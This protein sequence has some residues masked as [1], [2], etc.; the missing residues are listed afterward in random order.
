MLQW[1]TTKQV[2]FLKTTALVLVFFAV[3]FNLS[4]F[5]A[6][7]PVLA[8][9]VSSPD[10]TLNQ[11]LQVIEQ[12]L[13][14]A[15][16]DIR[17]IIARIIRIAL[18]LV[19]LV[20]VIMFIYAGFL[21]MTAGGN[22]EQLGRAKKILIN[23]TV[24]L[25]II[26]SAYAIVWFVMRL[27]GV[28]GQPGEVPP[29]AF[30]QNTQNFRGSGALGKIV[31]DHYPARDEVNIPRNTKLVITFSKPVLVSS[32]TN[33]TNRNG[34]FGD[35]VIPNGRALNWET[36]CDS[37]KLGDN[38]I[39]IS[40]VGSQ[41]GQL[42]LTPVRGAAVLA[43]YVVESG[44]R[45]SY[46]VVLRPYDVLGSDQE[47][48][49]YVVRLGDGIKLDLPNNPGAFDVAILGNNYYEWKFICSKVLDTVPPHV[50]N[51]Y[52]NDGDSVAKN[53]AIQINFDKPIDP[54]GVQGSF[55]VGAG[56][57]FLGGEVEA[58][59]YVYLT[60]PN[61]NAP[62][63][64]FN[65]VNNYRTLEFVSTLECGVNACGG[66]IF[67][68]PVCDK[69]G[70]NCA[71]DDYKI[72][73][74]AGLALDPQNNKF[75]A[76]PFSGIVDLSGNALDSG[77]VG[78]VEVAPRNNPIFVNQEQPDNYYWGFNV[79][80]E[81]DVTSPFINKVIPGLDAQNVAPNQVWSVEFNKKML[82]SSLYSISITEYP[83]PAARCVGR[84]NCEAVPMWKMPSVS[85]RNNTTVT[86]SHGP[87]LDGLRQYYLP[88]ISSDVT[89]VNYNCMYPGK[90][91]GTP[92]QVNAKLSES[93]VCDDTPANRAN[94]CVVAAA[95]PNGDAS[96]A[97]CCNGV[98][99]A[100]A[101]SVEECTNYWANNVQSP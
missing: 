33:N 47:E 19:G 24:G 53:T 65:L 52:P 73:L 70:A 29:V 20:M 46:T 34:V 66:K 43:S 81:L 11:G 86:I 40:S 101:A 77:V 8:Q 42:T 45:R 51:V 74:K 72:L 94:C 79:T 75:E 9:E 64:F 83:T 31:R 69:V 100:A 54:T 67:C 15:A 91:P 96:R 99:N 23:A 90:G 21:W 97:F 57:Y 13:G 37:L 92:A 95:A 39:N 84:Q 50:T 1:I 62:A 82:I 55:N 88:N 98:P 4:A 78:K 80:K 60:S 38:F 28:E 5:L 27:L 68:L 35:C 36:D 22:E 30:E 16:T 7:S 89:D 85:G 6:V 10:S 63:G 48:I 87:F 44:N 58:D 12:P 18:G 59:S 14:L 41:N 25:A 61:S 3:V 71:A 32:F 93:L 26:L 17:V 2:R 76:S 49:G 56:S